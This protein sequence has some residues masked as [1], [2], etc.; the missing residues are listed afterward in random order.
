[1]I[2]FEQQY[3]F[4]NNNIFKPHIKFW[5]RCRDDVYI[6]WNGASDTLDCFFW[7]LNYKE[8]KIEFT[9]EREEW[10]SGFSG[11]INTKMP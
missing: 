1:M 10:H 7:Q 9:I 5:K 2:W 11:H 8:P 3:V 4:S 6:I